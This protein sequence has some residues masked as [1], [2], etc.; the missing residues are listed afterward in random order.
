MT[1]QKVQGRLLSIDFL[2]VLAAIF[3][4]NSHFQPLYKD[5]SVSL[6]TFGVHGNA[7]FFFVSGFLLMMG[8]TKKRVDFANWYKARIR[9]LWPSVFLWGLVAAVVWSKPLTIGGLVLADGYWFL[10]AIVIAYALFY[11]LYAKKCEQILMGGVKRWILTTFI[12][13]LL[14]TIGVFLI[15]PKAEGSPF[16]TDLHYVCHFSVMVMGGMAYLYRDHIR[17]CCIWKDIC[18][19]ILSFVAYF[20][21]LAVL[22][23]RTDWTYYLQI[24]D[25]VPIH[26]FIYY[27]Y[28]VASYE[29]TNKLFSTRGV[30]MCIKVIAVLTLEIYI[31]QFDL[32][33]DRLNFLF[34]LNALIVFAIICVVAYLLRALT[35]LFLQVMS[36][37]PLDWRALYRI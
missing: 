19:V 37:E 34:P 2:K 20:A 31:V 35:T 16:H 33:T 8:F 25:I 18:G 32:L 5:V 3:I 14:A 17:C 4:T 13:S 23:G 11:I 1:D 26:A 9:R 30:G 21:L 28:K 29:W 10:Q 15:M 24:I 36:K 6:A 7:L 12:L 27:L 22:K